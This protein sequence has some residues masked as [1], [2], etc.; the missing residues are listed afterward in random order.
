M[1]QIED[2]QVICVLPVAV[3]TSYI[4]CSIQAT[5]PA[6]YVPA[7]RDVYEYFDTECA[8]ATVGLTPQLWYAIHTR[9]PTYVHK[10]CVNYK[11][12]KTYLTPKINVNVEKMKK[13]SP[14]SKL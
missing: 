6:V 8:H 9:T 7:W 13:F 4:H 14:T 2:S 1:L 12:K 3:Y 10:Y 5:H 11:A